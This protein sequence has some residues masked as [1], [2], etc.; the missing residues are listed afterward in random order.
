MVTRVSNFAHSQYLNSHLFKLQ[1]DL[2]KAEIATAT[3]KIT[4]TY[5]GIPDSSSRLVQLE[6]LVEQSRRFNTNNEVVDLRLQ[7]TDIALVGIEDT[8]SNMKDMLSDYASGET[9]SAE[10]V[11]QVQKFAYQAL[12]D[13][14][15]FLNESVA[16]RYLFSGSRTSQSPV[17]LKLQ[18][19]LQ[20]FQQ[21]W[22]GDT[23]KF[24]ET[25]AANILKFGI[26][27]SFTFTNGGS[28]NNQYSEIQIAGFAA[29]DY[30][31]FAVGADITLA[32]GTGNDGDWTISAVDTT[33]GYIR[34]AR[35][36]LTDEVSADTFTIKRGADEPLIISDTMTY[37]GTTIT[38]AGGA[39]TF[40]NVEVPATIEIASGSGNNT[41]R[42]SVTAVSADG[43]SLTVS[44]KTATATGPNAGTLNVSSYYNG[45]TM[46]TS[47]RIDENRSIDLDT[48]ALDPAF[49]KAI[50]ALSIIAQGEFGT[51]GGLDQ[52]TD[53]ADEAIWLLDSALD[54]PTDGTP[55][56]GPEDVSSIEQVRFETSFYRS[57]IKT[58][59]ERETTSI[60]FLLNNTGKIENI[61]RLQATTELLDIDRALQASYQVLSRTQ[62]LGL[63]QFL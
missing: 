48:T 17:D 60:T 28:G 27:D 49:D 61:D 34:V 53:R 13:I 39:G 32:G 62:K 55:P 54:F 6:H 23:S 2:H 10:Q 11:E 4:Q 41:M 46:I 52:N 30:S 18:D 26:S 37:S 16:G 1:N 38:A 57:Q 14:Q 9:R 33:T 8:I 58:S 35:K 47:H 63:A 19:N 29:A 25:R 24:P 31:K 51:A 45:D 36:D 5:S 22:N 12:R 40:S 21:K 15:G 50:R 7:S 20:A 56:Y 44:E 43:S 42:V 3:E 59:I